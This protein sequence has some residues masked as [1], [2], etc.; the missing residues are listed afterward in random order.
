MTQKLARASLL[1]PY[2]GLSLLVSPDHAQALGNQS[3]ATVCG[4]TTSCTRQCRSG[5]RPDDWITCGV[6]GDCAYCTPNWQTVSSEPALGYIDHNAYP[7][8]Q[9]FAMTGTPNA[10]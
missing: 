3:C 8:C 6:W 7:F 4:P 9:T 10:T 1:V 2:L 5:D